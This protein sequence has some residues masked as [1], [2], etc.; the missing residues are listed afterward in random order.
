MAAEASILKSAPVCRLTSSVQRIIFA[1]R[2]FP[3][4][5]LSVVWMLK[6]EKLQFAHASWKDAVKSAVLAHN[7]PKM[8]REVSRIVE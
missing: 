7:N 2:N 3:L 5:T 4:R 8:A 1:S 6:K